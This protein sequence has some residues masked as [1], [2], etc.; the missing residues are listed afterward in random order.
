MKSIAIIIPHHNDVTRLKQFLATLDEGFFK[1]IIIVDDASE[2]SELKRLQECVKGFHNLPITL[3][4]QPVQ[5]GAGAA[6][7]QGLETV[8]TDFVIFVDS[9]DRFTSNY[10]EI[11]TQAMNFD[12][13]VVYVSPTSHTP[14][15][16]LGSRHRLYQKLIRG[17]LQSQNSVSEARLSTH[18]FIPTSKVI[19]TSLIQRH[20]LRFDEIMVSN[21]VM[22]SLSVGLYAQKIEAIDT[23]FYSILAHDSGLTKLKDRE[24]VL[25]RVH[26]FI[27][28]VSAIREHYD[29]E[30]VKN[31]KMRGDHFVRLGLKSG[32][33]VFAKEIKS[34]LDLN[35][36]EVSRLRLLIKTKHWI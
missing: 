20:Q 35:H 34:L 12:V 4:V 33:L 25:T 29:S 36:I 8:N 13:D 28:F 30:I 26:V 5:R 16:E 15:Q 14:S 10:Q 11:I 27:R 21:D 24:S 19:K 31:L 7:N 9:D 3:H 6:R 2:S 17:Y 18:F 23:P 32:G 22:F 1:Q